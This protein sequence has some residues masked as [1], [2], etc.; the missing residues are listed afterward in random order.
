MAPAEISSTGSLENDDK[1]G[2]WCRCTDFA[3][4]VHEKSSLHR[5]RVLS[6]PKNLTT[7]GYRLIDST[8]IRRYTERQRE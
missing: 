1:D 7:T 3:E 6:G 8:P 4:E 2:H 5:G